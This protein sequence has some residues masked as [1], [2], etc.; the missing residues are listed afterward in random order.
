MVHPRGM[1]DENNRET[2]LC[3][4]QRPSHEEYDKKI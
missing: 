2:K 1:P 4:G 3:H